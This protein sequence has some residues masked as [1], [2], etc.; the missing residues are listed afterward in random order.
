[1]V[2]LWLLHVL[3][4]Y[5]SL[6]RSPSLY[7]SM[8]LLPP[9]GAS[10]SA[11][12][13]DE[14][15]TMIDLKDAHDRHTWARKDHYIWRGLRRDAADLFGHRN[16]FRVIVGAGGN[17]KKKKDSLELSYL[18]TDAFKARL[19]SLLVGDAGAAL[20][21]FPAVIFRVRKDLMT[22][23]VDSVKHRVPSLGTHQS[24]DIFTFPALFQDYC[25]DAGKLEFVEEL[26]TGRRYYRYT[27][28]DERMLRD[29]AYLVYHVPGRRLEPERATDIELVSGMRVG[30]A[31]VAASAVPSQDPVLQHVMAMWPKATG[32]RAGS[33]GA[34]RMHSPYDSAHQQA[35]RLGE[36]YKNMDDAMHE[37]SHPQ[38]LLLTRPWREVV[39]DATLVSELA[40]HGHDTHTEAHQDEALAASERV[41][42]YLSN[43]LNF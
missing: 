18:N 34:A 22:W 20:E 24:G 27:P 42:R 25:P 26:R 2:L 29:W 37:M 5:I 8:A 7:I 19:V 6:T 9:I 14:R 32:T 3:V 11:D 35:K 12:K 40:R 33:E 1:M 41:T 23:L 43:T 15:V 31:S 38:T 13:H 39:G 17:T 10:A 16:T 28:S 4:L 36:A 30:F 21:L